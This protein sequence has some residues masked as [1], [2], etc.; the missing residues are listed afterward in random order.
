MQR[1]LFLLTIYAFFIS[2]G[3]AKATP[4]DSHLTRAKELYGAG[5]WVDARYELLKAKDEVK[6]GNHIEKQEV[7]YYLTLCSIGMEEESALKRLCYFSQKY[8]C[9]P[10]TNQINFNKG[11]LL[12]MSQEYGSA[13]EE[14]LG[15][16][17]SKLSRSQREDYDIRMGYITFVDGDYT[18]AKGYFER[19]PL[20]SEYY[21]HSLYY[22]SYIDY[23]SGELPKAKDGFTR[24]TQSDVYGVIAPYYLLQIEFQQG[25]YRYVIEQGEELLKRVTTEQRAEI[26]RTM[27]ES[28]FRLD[29]FEGAIRYISL[30]ETLGA[31]MSR[32]DNYILGFSLYRLTDYNRA[33]EHLRKASGADDALTQNASFHLA[34]CYLRMG[35]KK[36]A[37]QAFAMASSDKY[38]AEIAEDALF[39]YGKLQ[40]ELGGGVFNEA[41]NVLTRYINKYPNSN[42]VTEAKKLLAAAYYN[43]SSYD[44]AYKAIKEIKSPDADIRAALQKI[45]YFRAL[46]AMNRGDYTLAKSNF[47]ESQSAGISPKYSAL[48]EFWLGEIAYFEGDYSSALKSFNTYLVRAPKTDSTYAMAQYSTAYA[49]LKGGNESAALK[50]FRSYLDTKPADISLRTD[51]QNRVGDI[52]YGERKFAEASKSYALSAKVAGAGGDYARYQLSMVDGI[53]GFIDRKISGLGAIVKVGKGAYA[54]DALYEL[55]RTHMA[56]ESYKK[57]IEDLEL[58]ISKYPASERYAQALS[59]LGLSYL[60]LG[61]KSTSISYYDRAIKSAPQSS[62]SKDALQGIRE[63]YVGG[64]DANGYFEYAQQ[65]GFDSDLGATAKDSLSFASAQYLYLQEDRARATKALASYIKD[66][67]QGYYLTDALFLLSDCYIKAGANDKAIE[68]LAALSN[69]G[70]N[71]YTQRVLESLSRL[72]HNAGEYEQAASAYRKLYDVTKSQEEKAS[73]MDGYAVCVIALGDRDKSL[74][75]ADDILSQEQAG[76]KAILKAKYVKATILRENGNWTEAVALYEDLATQ[77]TTSVGAEARYYLISNAHRSGNIDQAEKMIFEFSDSGTTQAYWLARA[78]ITLGDI[79]AVRGDSF[80]ARATYQSIV[81]GY[82]TEDDGVRAEAISKIEKLE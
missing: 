46:E 27:A 75:M 8:A 65:M 80:Q 35:N 25:N 70:A 43:S 45:T 54:D 79:Y 23:A 53:R 50:Y 29:D 18:S 77:P 33:Q 74:A 60:N 36:G 51:V 22:R 48:S 26:A 1:V 4:I 49:L 73:A 37:M 57:A 32:E 12:S 30:Y 41:I 28:C 58:F 66:Y 68:S 47:A 40:F 2:V 15:V 21:D 11:L 10:Y 56:Q 72:T 69:R 64:G 63:I 81:D 39:N 61:D 16:D 14:F 34:D 20:G 13:R 5:R 24:L 17:Y 6:R 67:E 52:L 62:V 55:G 59:D 78:F 7:E 76:V 71:Q 31:K 3:V 42:R 38:N 9:S 44:A 19:I 82:A